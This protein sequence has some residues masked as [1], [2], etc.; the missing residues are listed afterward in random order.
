MESPHVAGALSGAG[1]ILAEAP[2]IVAAE[3]LTVGDTAKSSY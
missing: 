2:R 1:D 3:P